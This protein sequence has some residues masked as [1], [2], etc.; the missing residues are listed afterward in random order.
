MEY[1]VR[2]DR[3]YF[4]IEQEGWKCLTMEFFKGPTLE[5]EFQIGDKEFLIWSQNS[6]G[7]SYEIFRSGVSRGRIKYG[8]T[9]AKISIK[10]DFLEEDRQYFFRNK[11]TW[12]RQ[13]KLTNKEDK[14][15]LIMHYKSE[16]KGFDILYNLR[17]QLVDLSLSEAEEIECVAYACFVASMYLNMNMNWRGKK[18]K[19]KRFGL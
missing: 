16:F 19:G 1:R 17:F 3:G 13:Y 10:S 15:I 4:Y 6:L 14:E 9:G 11:S 8:I 5:A 12:R 18:R 2:R 7:T